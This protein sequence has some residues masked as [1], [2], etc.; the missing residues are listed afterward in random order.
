MPVHLLLALSLALPR[1]TTADTTYYVTN[2]AR[3]SGRFDRVH[4]DS[5]EFGIVVTRFVGQGGNTLADR[6]TEKLSALQVDSLQLT[7]DDFLA[8][9]RV[10]D[11]QA[12]AAGEGA[13]L[14]VHGYAT[15]FRRGILQAAEIAH[16]ERLR[17]PMIVFSWPAHRTFASWPSFGA[18]ISGIYRDDALSAARSEE[19]FRS[20]LAVVTSAVH[21]GAL[22]VVGYSLGAQLVAE[23]LRAPTPIHD[24]LGTT[25]L[26]ALVF[27]APDVAADRF[28]DSLAAPMASLALRRVVYA[29][30][31]DR[32]L[33]LSRLVNHSVRA[34]QAGGERML[35]ESDLEMVDVSDGRR[36]SSLAR[37]LFD[38]RHSMRFA[39]SALYDFNGVVRGIGVECRE[40]EGIAVRATARSWKLTGAPIP[41]QATACA[42]VL[43]SSAERDP[44]L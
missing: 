25:P 29:S 39:S 28:R 37:R 10:A 18:L 43:H 44:G 15:S 33:T 24:A 14:Y 42:D 3:L 40:V 11:A 1:D 9:L 30:R 8:R 36:T 23:A 19:S 41:R 4:G 20:A 21:P 22:T 7:R 27:F 35:A 16:R 6:L 12:T 31:A 32:M 26:R 34:G 17:G 13:V 2:R 5:L 38:P